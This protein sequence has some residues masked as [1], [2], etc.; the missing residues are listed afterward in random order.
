MLSVSVFE[1][2]SIRSQIAKLTVDVVLKEKD[3]TVNS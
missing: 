1:A 2:G 3:G